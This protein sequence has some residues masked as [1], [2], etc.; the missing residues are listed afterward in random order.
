[1]F[2][3]SDDARKRLESLDNIL[4]PAG[5]APTASI[6]PA[7]TRAETVPDE[8]DDEGDEDDEVSADV[9]EIIAPHPAKDVLDKLDSLLHPKVNG[10]ARYAGK[11]PSQIGIAETSLILG[12]KEGSELFDLSYS[13]AHAYE[14]AAR[15]SASPAIKPELKKAIDKARSRIAVQAADRLHAVLTLLDDDKLS[16]VKRATNLA[17]IGKDMAVILDK[18]TPKEA[19]HKDGLHFHIYRPEMAVASAYETVEL[20]PV[21][22]VTA[23]LDSQ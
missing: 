6:T 23:K 9:Q 11:L 2:V 20:G 13:Q 1:M 14:G 4:R 5:V 19:E 3:S 17:K 21:L 15:T 18:V 22:D 16:K 7:I 8:P 12:A 10:R